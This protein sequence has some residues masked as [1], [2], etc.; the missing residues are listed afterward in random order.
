[1]VIIR[2]ADDNPIGAFQSVYDSLRH[3]ELPLPLRH[4]ALTDGAPRVGVF[5][6][7]DGEADGMLESLCMQAVKDKPETSC[8]DAY[9]NCVAEKGLNPKPLEKAR[10]HA[11]LAS[12]PEPDKRVG[13]AAQA[14][15]WPFGHPVFTNLWQFI[16]EM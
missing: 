2:D 3:H 9:I 4:G 8:L 11:W 16:R 7:P 15:Y 12:Q 1:L 14:G 13:E 5:I 6:M 10:V